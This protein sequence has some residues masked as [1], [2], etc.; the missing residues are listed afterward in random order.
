MTSHSH[1]VSGFFVK[2]EEAENARAELIERGLPLERLMIYH[3]STS[4]ASPTPAAK[5]NALLKNML[6][7]GAIG[8]AVGSGVGV[9]AELALVAANVTLFVASPLVAPL[10]MLGWGASLGG[11]VGAVVGAGIHDKKEGKLADLVQD[12]VMN[13]QVVLVAR[14]VTADETAAAKDVILESVGG[15]TDTLSA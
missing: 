2:L 14:T 15:V 6:T 12:A 10:A 8:T 9:L 1:H 5:S 4:A 3:N 11:V 7:D 13:G